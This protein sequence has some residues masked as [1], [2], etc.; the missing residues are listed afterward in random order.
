[1]AEA[2]LDAPFG[3]V[4]LRSPVGATGPVGSAD[5]H[6]PEDLRVADCLR[7]ELEVAFGAG[8]T[9]EFDLSCALAEGARAT[10][11]DGGRLTWPVE[12]PGLIG[13]FAIPSFDDLI[14]AAGVE[15][16]SYAHAT[17][18]VSFRLRSP[19]TQVLKLRLAAAWTA[20]PM[21]EDDEVAPAIAVD[22]ALN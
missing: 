11:E 7:G 4:T 1:M 15:V 16:V 22:L 10:F 20:D 17:A 19:A 12:A 14:H 6:L 13:A 5:P 8:E 3:P 21:T 2:R 9:V 18:G